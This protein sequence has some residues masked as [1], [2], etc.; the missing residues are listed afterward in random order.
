M[1]CIAVDDELLALN[2]IKDFCSRI[3]FLNLI[4]TCSNAMDAIKLINKH[5]I[6]LIFLDIQMPYITGVEFCK[7]LG[8]TYSPL[9]IFTT[10]YSDHALEGFELNAV[11]YLIKPI[12]FE[13]FFQSVNKAYELIE[14][15]K[16]KTP[17]HVIYK[18][19]NAEQP[20]YLMIK[21]EYTTVKIIFKNI[22]YIE[23]LKD[24][25]KIFT[26]EKMFLT[27]S[28]MKNIEAKL[29]NN[30]FMRVHKSF[31]VSLPKINKLENNRIIFG[32]KRI[33]VGDQYK[34]TFHNLINEY[35]L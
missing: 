2:V 3:P 16:K 21:C 22:I 13:R 25:I 10:A 26:E 30:I 31:I 5:E 20:G 34:K 6:D 23:G 19:T 18:D 15:R 29:P 24:Y 1:N 9:I 17:S 14:L 8:T 33:P 27:K 35:R 32:D 11:D 4:E 28:T 12:P 7:S